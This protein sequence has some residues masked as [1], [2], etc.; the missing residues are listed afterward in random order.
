MPF[1]PLMKGYKIDQPLM[2]H[3]EFMRSYYIL[4]KQTRKKGNNEVGDRILIRKTENIF[5]G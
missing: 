4:S 1:S 5:K 3:F 2:H